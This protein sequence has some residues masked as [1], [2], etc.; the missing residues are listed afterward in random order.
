[1]NGIKTLEKYFKAKEIV[2]TVKADGIDVNRGTAWLIIE[3][4]RDENN[5]IEEIKIG[6]GNI[7]PITREYLLKVL[8]NSESQNRLLDMTW[9]IAYHE[10]LEAK[11]EAKS[12]IKS[13]LAD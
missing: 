13:I 2:E 1:M 6:F 12:A 9:N 5:T 11:E 7:E 8:L 10:Y 3:G 4:K